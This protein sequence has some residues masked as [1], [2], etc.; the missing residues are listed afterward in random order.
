VGGG[1]VS[2]PPLTQGPAPA[3]NRAWSRRGW[4]S[5][6][7][8]GRSVPGLMM[9]STIV[10]TRRTRVPDTLGGF[11]ATAAALLYSGPAHV[12]HFEEQKPVL[13]GAEIDTSGVTI[14][15]HYEIYMPIPDDPAKVP[16]TGDRV[17]FNDGYVTYDLPIMHVELNSGLTDHL[18]IWVDNVESV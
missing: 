3:L 5:A 12:E 15:H 4:A 8:F 13:G 10:V 18:E 7:F 9:E 6:P 11:G 2:D 16:D 17:Q 14:Y 1:A